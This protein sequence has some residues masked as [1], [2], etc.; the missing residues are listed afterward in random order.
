MVQARAQNSFQAW[1]ELGEAGR[2][3]GWRCGGL[4][5][6]VLVEAGQDGQLGVISSVSCSD[7]QVCGVVRRASVITAGSFA[8]VFASPGRGR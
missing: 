7:R 2:A 3:S 8:S 4:G 6:E 1:V 5:R